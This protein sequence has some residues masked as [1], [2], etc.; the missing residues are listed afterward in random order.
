MRWKVW[1]L[2]E[3]E[4]KEEFEQ[5]VVDLVDTEAVDLWESYKNVVLKACGLKT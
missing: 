4:I 2:K 5:R 3:T 1:K